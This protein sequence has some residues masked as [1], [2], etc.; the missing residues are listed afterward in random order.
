MDVREREA[1][2]EPNNGCFQTVVLEKTLEGPLDC[3]IK[4][5]NPKRNQ[6]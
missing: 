2:G 3:K 1:E 6:S 4:L 5:A